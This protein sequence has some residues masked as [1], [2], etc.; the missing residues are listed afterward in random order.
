M[1]VQIGKALDSIVLRYPPNSA[2]RSSWK[3]A[4]ETIMKKA[5]GF[6][7]LASENSYLGVGKALN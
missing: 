1:H 6:L 3:V 5:P 2:Y 7:L 4:L